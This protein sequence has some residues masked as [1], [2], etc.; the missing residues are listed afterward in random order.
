M[1]TYKNHSPY[2]ATDQF[3]SA[4]DV[5]TL[6]QI[7]KDPSDITYEIDEV[8]DLRPDLLANDLYDNPNL[9]WVFAVR[10]P[11]VLYDPVFDFR[12]GAVI[13]LPQRQGLFAALGI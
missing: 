4:L 12:A 1:V 2:A 6:R 11:N 8:Y 13:R 10:N 9:W 3:G 7:P 5:L